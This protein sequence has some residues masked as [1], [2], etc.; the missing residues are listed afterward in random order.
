[1]KISLTGRLRF[2]AAVLLL[3]Y[4]SG[5]LISCFTAFI[6]PCFFSKITYFA[7]GFPLIFVGYLFFCLPFI[8]F[9][10]RK[11]FIA[12]LLLLIPSWKNISSVLSFHLPKTF[13]LN[14]EADA[15]RILSWNVNAFLYKPYIILDRAA[16]AEQDAMVE[17]IRTTRPHILCFQDFAEAP[18]EYGR[19]NIRFLA[20]SLGYPYHYFSEDG[21]NYGTIQ[22]SRLPIIDS[23]RIRYTERKFPESLAFIDV[24]RGQDTL[25][26]YNTHLRSMNL[27][28]EKITPQNIGYIEFVKEDTAVLYHTGRLGRLEYF[29]CIHAKQAA[30]V[31]QELDACKL[32]F[33]FCADLNAVPSSYVY[34]HI[35]KNL[36]DAFLSAGSGISGT[37]HRFT[38]ALR[39]D[40]MLVSNQLNP[41]QFYN[42]KPALSDHYP[43]ITDILLHK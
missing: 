21:D 12:A 14:K 20:D 11:Y 40:V 41:V 39:I 35:R 37:Y 13:A 25:R 5:Y 28:K 43:L 26:I 34:Q 16:Q 7:L 19:V 23:G 17:L 3:V 2:F 38:P 30:T 33:V 15:I 8:F 31:K 42:P 36:K 29:D 22:F 24:L 32:P 10:F 1:M 9:F 6:N 4:I 18:A 27:H